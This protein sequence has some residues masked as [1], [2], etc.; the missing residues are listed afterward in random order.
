MYCAIYINERD[1]H[2]LILR[3]YM[4][5]CMYMYLKCSMSPYVGFVR[6]NRSPERAFYVSQAQDGQAPAQGQREQLQSQVQT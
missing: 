4:C 3:A 6:E 2:N 5:A 1:I